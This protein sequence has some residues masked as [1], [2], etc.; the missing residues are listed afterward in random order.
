MLRTFWKFG[1]ILNQA[2]VQLILEW[3]IKSY[4]SVFSPYSAYLLHIQTVVLPGIVISLD[5]QWPGRETWTLTHLLL[6][7]LFSNHCRLRA[8]DVMESC[9]SY[10]YPHTRVHSIVGILKTTAH[11]AFPVVTVDKDEPGASSD[12]DY[13]GNPAS[14]NE[15]YARRT[16]SSSLTSEQKTRGSSLI[17]GSHELLDRQ[18]NSSDDTLLASSAPPFQTAIS[19]MEPTESTHSYGQS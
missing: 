16:T 17:L 8:S 10:V 2:T 6:C 19:N 15:R 18:L 11:N 9:L 3:V 7:P 14:A 1:L 12:A 13:G 5:T 4:W